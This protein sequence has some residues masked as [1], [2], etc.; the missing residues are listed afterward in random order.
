MLDFLVKGGVAWLTLQRPKVLNA[1][2]REL[3]DALC[4]RIE[5]L[6]NRADVRVVVT[7]GAGK[8]FCAG[9]D[10]RELAPLSA[11]EAAA[12]ELEFAE[13]FAKL[14]DLPQP[15][16]AMVHG[17]ALG[18]GLG[19]ALYHDFRVAATAASLGMPEVELGWIP[20]WAVGRLA[21]TVGVAQARWLL[22]S[23][24][25]L[26]GTQAAAIG[27]VNEAVP[28]DQL[29]SRVEELATR[30]ASMPAEGLSSTKAFLN[31]ISPLRHFEHDRRASEN[32]RDCYAK[33]A[34][35]ERV[36]N[37]LARKAKR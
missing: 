33:P 35:Q 13:I 31:R 5:E 6:E 11:P 4:L 29:L 30:L 21:E 23:C 3:A 15:T 10:L 1:M 32:F 25:L 8:A 18:G 16:I 14:D 36:R 12:Y 24:K 28:E 7:R 22:M 9:S 26:T 2:N 37:F 17:Y 27:L 20:P 34:A 19:L